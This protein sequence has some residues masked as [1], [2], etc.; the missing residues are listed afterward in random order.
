VINIESYK[1]LFARVQM[2]M[3]IYIYTYSSA[4]KVDLIGC[5]ILLLLFCD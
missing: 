3:H 2:F 4:S 1:G 5:F